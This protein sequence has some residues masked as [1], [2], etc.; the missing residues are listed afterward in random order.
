MSFLH[1]VQRFVCLLIANRF[2]FDAFG[3][4]FGDIP[5]RR[6]FDELLSFF[7]RIFFVVKGM[8]ERSYAN[9]TLADGYLDSFR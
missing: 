8:Y 4:F 1:S 6:I 9:L 3:L 2:L 5:A 7:Y